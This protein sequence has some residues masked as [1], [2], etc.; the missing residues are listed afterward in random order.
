MKLFFYTI[1]MIVVPIGTYFF[2]L[3]VIFRGD[4]NKTGWSGIGAVFMCNIIIAAYVVAAWREG[5]DEDGDVEYVY[6]NDGREEDIPLLGGNT[7]QSIRKRVAAND[8]DYVKKEIRSTTAKMRQ[9]DANDVVFVC[10]QVKSLFD[11]C[12]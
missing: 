2:L 5:D 10:K 3:N 7:E 4:P 6:V 1:L 9:T 8:S 12:I 11:D